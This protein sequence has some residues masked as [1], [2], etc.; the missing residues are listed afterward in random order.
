M[1]NLHYPQS[2]YVSD[3]TKKLWERMVHTYYFKDSAIEKTVQNYSSTVNILCDY[4]KKDFMDITDKEAVEFVE[5]LDVRVANTGQDHLSA[6]TAF[7]YKKNLR[8]VGNYF[9]KLL[10]KELGEKCG[11]INPFRG[12]AVKNEA[13]KA[14]EH[15]FMRG[16]LKEQVRKEDVLELLQQVKEQEA[17]QYY[18]ILCMIACFGV[19]SFDICNMRPEQVYFVEGEAK[20]QFTFYWKKRMPKTRDD[21]Q[22]N[23][24]DDTK[25]EELIFAFDDEKMVCFMEFWQMEHLQK[26]QQTREYVFYN[27]NSNPVNFKTISSVLKKHKDKLNISYSLTTKELSG[28]L[29][30]DQY[31]IDRREKL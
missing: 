14:R 8:S 22:D 24:L 13:V 10:E 25:T 16:R 7:T 5:Y 28:I 1:E 4:W 11:Y 19:S 12:K 27:R 20:V 21:A 29:F 6:S 17:P 2:Q 9:E 26:M 31:L 18:I 3:K 15:L 23:R 30:S